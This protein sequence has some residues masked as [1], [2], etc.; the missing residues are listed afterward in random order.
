MSFPALPWIAR[1]SNRRATLLPS[2]KRRTSLA[3]VLILVCRVS[4]PGPK[5]RGAGVQNVVGER[6]RWSLD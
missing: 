6:S 1:P 3:F 4:I 5:G 2:Q